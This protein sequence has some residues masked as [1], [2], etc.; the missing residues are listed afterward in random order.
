MIPLILIPALGCGARLYEE[1]TACLP[2][3]SACRALTASASSLADCAEQILSQA[4]K[5]F[6]VLGTS[7]GGAVAAQVAVLAPDR[8][9]GLIIIGSWPGAAAD[10]AAGMRRAARLRGNEF[11]A[12]VSEMAAMIAHADGP[13]G[14]LAQSTFVAMARIQGGEFMARQSEAMAH[15]P[16][17][18]PKLAALHSPALLI[19]GEHDKFVPAADGRRLAAMIPGSRYVELPECGH[20]PSLEYP[21]KTAQIIEHWLIDHG[22]T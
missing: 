11:E 2:E 13:R 17:L 7:F 1:M 21:E 8:V 14:P 12:V 19:W 5:S 20:L 4:P 6:I 9:K 10:P 22:L 3:P 15:R 16:D 18:L